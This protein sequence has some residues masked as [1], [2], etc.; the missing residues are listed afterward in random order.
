MKKIYLSSQN[1]CIGYKARRGSQE[2]MLYSNLNFKLYSGELTCLLGA[3]GTGKSTLLK[4]LNSSLTP[5]S[6]EVLLMGANI[7]S[8]SEN[9]LSKHLGI[10]LTEKINAGGLLVKEIVALGRYPYTGFWGKNNQHDND[11]IKQAME[12]VCIIHKADCYISELSDGERQKAM[13][14]KALAQECPIIL[15]DEPTAFLDATSRIE[16]MSLLQQLAKTKEKAILLS[17]HDLDLAL[18]MADR[19]W[20]LSDENGLKCGITEDIILS[21][22]INNYLGRENIQFSL[23]T[24]SFKPKEQ[25]RQSVKVI[26]NESLKKWIRNFL[27]RHNFSVADGQNVE[28]P[29]KYDMEVFS[30]NE[31]IL[32]ALSDME[33]YFFASFDEL[34]AFLDEQK[35]E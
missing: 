4:T 20:L 22:D 14:A 18:S 16:I 13:I 28:T 21:D 33:N 19:L 3:N 7:K 23:E 11:I 8:Y 31:I 5:L 29:I 12:S 6:G 27:I 24:G 1:L 10:V 15:L 9:E 2:T 32:R 30:K 25:Y 35:G 26:A 34:S 17:T